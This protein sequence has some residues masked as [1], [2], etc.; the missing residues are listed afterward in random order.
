[1]KEDNP[2][3]IDSKGIPGKYKLDEKYDRTNRYGIFGD[4]W[5]TEEIYEADK[6]NQFYVHPYNPH[7]IEAKN[8]VTSNKL[9]DDDEYVAPK[10]Q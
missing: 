7:F 6:E 4:N 2:S 1:L 5:D 9:I 8:F 10:T 3:E